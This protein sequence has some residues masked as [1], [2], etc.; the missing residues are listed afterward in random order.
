MKI[1]LSGNI[2][3]QKSSIYSADGILLQESFLV[4]A[5]SSQWHRQFPG[6]PRRQWKGLMLNCDASCFVT[7]F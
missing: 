1:E 6:L 5:Y 2:L 4:G 7:V 3:F